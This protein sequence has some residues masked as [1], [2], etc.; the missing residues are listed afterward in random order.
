MPFVVGVGRFAATTSQRGR[1]KPK[2]GGK[3][4]KTRQAAASQ[5]VVAALNVA[6]GKRS[7]APAKATIAAEGL[8]RLS[9]RPVFVKLLTPSPS[10]PHRQSVLYFNRVSSEDAPTVRNLRR[11]VTELAS[12]SE[13]QHL[14]ILNGRLVKEDMSLQELEDGPVATV[15]MI[16]MARC[17]CDTDGHSEWTICATCV[18]S[19]CEPCDL[20]RHLRHEMFPSFA[21]RNF[22]E[23]TKK[24]SYKKL[25][26]PSLTSDIDMLPLKAEEMT[27]YWSHGCQLQSQPTKSVFSKDIEWV[28]KCLARFP[29][30]VSRV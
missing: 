14:L 25:K 7:A 3:A 8:P 9:S 13:E 10:D 23:T 17:R 28:M 22:F 29:H 1:P 11:K 16:P 4:K 12:I 19:F 21:V 6:S 20:V 15:L 26:M 5:A 2:I 24:R 18:T 27:T 30:E